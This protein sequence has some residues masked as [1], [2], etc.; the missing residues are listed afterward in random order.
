MNGLRVKAKKTFKRQ[1]QWNLEHTLLCTQVRRL[2]ENITLDHPVPITC[3]PGAP[4]DCCLG[5]LKKWLDGR[6]NQEDTSST[7]TVSNPEAMLKVIV[8]EHLQDEIDEHFHLGIHRITFLEL[9]QTFRFDD[10]L[11][12]LLVR[13]V[14]GFYKVHQEL[15]PHQPDAQS[16]CFYLGIRGYYTVIWRVHREE[17]GSN[18]GLK[19][20]AVIICHRELIPDL[21]ET[22]GDYKDLAGHPLMLL[23][24]CAGHLLQDID[25]KVFSH[26]QKICQTEEQTSFGREISPSTSHKPGR[27]RKTNQYEEDDLGHLSANMSSTLA[28]LALYL[29]HLKLATV[30]TDALAKPTD[31]QVALPNEQDAQTRDIIETSDTVQILNIDNGVHLVSSKAR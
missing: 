24:A 1:Q 19:T 22:L 13:H 25:N 9:F 7:K 8:I 29:K 15:Q 3:P 16:T 31:Q 28:G 12:Y 17:G 27:K 11:L 6:T 4:P 2:A 5:R 10:Y 30:I 21:L 23:L 20:N 14:D 18:A 26:L